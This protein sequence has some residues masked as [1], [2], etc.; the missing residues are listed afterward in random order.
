MLHWQN[1]LWL[2][3][4]IRKSDRG[5]HGGLGCKGTPFFPSVCSGKKGFFLSVDHALNGGGDPAAQ[6]DKRVF[7]AGVVD[8][9][10]H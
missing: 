8:R 3:M 9:Q 2:P 5:S 1:A 4:V 6:P 10:D 7:P